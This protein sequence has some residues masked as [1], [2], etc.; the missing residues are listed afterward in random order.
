MLSG[1]PARVRQVNTKATVAINHGKGA[2]ECGCARS[3]SM[4]I[5]VARTSISKVSQ[6]A[7]ALLRVINQ[8]TMVM[9]DKLKSVLSQR[10]LSCTPY[11]SESKKLTK[12]PIKK[13]A[14]IITEARAPSKNCE[15]TTMPFI[16]QNT[17]QLRRCGFVLPF[18][19]DSA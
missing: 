10:E 15:V 17:N 13:M 9:S 5:L 18:I 16:M 14:D 12:L 8:I 3:L 11:L 2:S 6:M 19:I 4:I 7:V 1:L